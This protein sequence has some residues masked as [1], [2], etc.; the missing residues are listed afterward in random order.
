MKFRSYEKETNDFLNTLPTLT[1]TEKQV[2]WANDVRAKIVNDI[3][4]W[5][6]I[7]KNLPQIMAAINSGDVQYNPLKK[8][9]EIINGANAQDWIALKDKGGLKILQDLGIYGK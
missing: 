1:G 7:D 9:M 5:T 2:K 4:V 6:R 3:I 8:L